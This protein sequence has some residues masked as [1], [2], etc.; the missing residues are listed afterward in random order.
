MGLGYAPLLAKWNR[1]V[2]K[3]FLPWLCCA[4]EKHVMVAEVTGKRVLVC[5]WISNLVGYVEQ[6]NGAVVEAMKPGFR[7]QVF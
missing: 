3:V 4:A 7:V 2:G 5:F 1:G 6:R